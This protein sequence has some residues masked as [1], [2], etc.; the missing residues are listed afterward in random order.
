MA[1]LRPWSVALLLALLGPVAQ[2][3][4]APEAE[5]P[6]ASTVPSLPLMQ[7]LLSQAPPRSWLP[8]GSRRRASGQAL[9]YMR[10]LY[11]SVADRHGRPRRDERLSSNTIRLVRPSAKA[12]QAGAGELGL[13]ACSTFLSGRR[14]GQSASPGGGQ[15][16][17]AGLQLSRAGSP[18]PQH[19]WARAAGKLP[20]LPGLPCSGALPLS[21]KGLSLARRCTHLRHELHVCLAH[22]GDGIF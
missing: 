3:R 4:E 13:G 11:R 22:E 7:M 20:A 2:A 14:A 16:P 21:G 12:R 1:G 15:G 8:G 10:N 5:A 17:C 9:R 19:R 6:A 18:S